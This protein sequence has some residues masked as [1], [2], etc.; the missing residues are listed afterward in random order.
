MNQDSKVHIYTHE[1]TRP[2]HVVVCRLVLEPSVDGS[3]IALCAISFVAR[4]CK[5]VPM[6]VHIHVH[7]HTTFVELASLRMVE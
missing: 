2:E 5:H 1:H 6:H 7:A 4:T 3:G